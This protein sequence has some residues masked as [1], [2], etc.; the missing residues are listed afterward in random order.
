MRLWATLLRSSERLL[1]IVIAAMVLLGARTASAAVPMCSEDG[2]TV[3]APPSA[4]PVKGHE[5]KYV[6]P[7]PELVRLLLD[8]PLH[9]SH[10]PRPATERVDDAPR[11]VPGR[12]PS[13]VA[14]SGT[15]VPVD[16]DRPIAARGVM[17]SIDRPPRV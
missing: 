6:A 5:L 8:A 1:P 2:R 7:C 9:D 3:A 15:R 12:L 14:P 11:G 16:F 4:M 10:K 17:T 13:L